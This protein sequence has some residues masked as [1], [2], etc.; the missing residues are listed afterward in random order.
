MKMI[1]VSEE[2]LDSIKRM[3]EEQSKDAARY[4]YLK[5]NGN[6]KFCIIDCEDIYN[7]KEYFVETI[8][9]LIDAEMAKL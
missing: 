5:N 7:L 9:K 4:R 8:D 3:A 2:A 1:L 6:N